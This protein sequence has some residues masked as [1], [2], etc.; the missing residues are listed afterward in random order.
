M[1]E[2]GSVVH[3]LSPKHDNTIT[4]P[5]APRVRVVELPSPPSPSPT[6]ITLLGQAWNNVSQP[7][8]RSPTIYTPDLSDGSSEDED[9]DVYS[10]LVTPRRSPSLSLP[11]SV[12]SSPKVQAL[13]C[14]DV[15][16]VPAKQT[17]AAA[18]EG[19]RRAQWT[20]NGAA[21]R[22]CRLP[23]AAQPPEQEDSECEDNKRTRSARPSRSA[24]TRRGAHKDADHDFVPPTR[25]S[26]S[27]RLS[28]SSAPHNLAS[29]RVACRYVSRSGVQCHQSTVFGG[30]PR[31]VGELHATDE[32]D[33]VATGEK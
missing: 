9:I 4:Y 29:G 32:A 1:I 30:M 11:P 24:T 20:V 16:P 27:S 8:S 3:I 5:P 23:R 19:V 2:N 25:S 14:L 7:A 33:E 12:P 17:V 6:T 22:T 26:R 28:S 31:H 15:G 18:P 10:P 21:L 13:S